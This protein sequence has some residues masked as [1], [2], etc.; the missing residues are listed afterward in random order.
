MAE[1]RVAEEYGVDAAAMLLAN[2]DATVAL[3]SGVESGAEAGSGSGGS[4][5]YN[6]QP[7]EFNNCVAHGDMV[8]VCED[9]CDINSCPDS[10]DYPDKI[11]YDCCCD[12]TNWHN[13][14]GNEDKPGWSH[15]CWSQYD[16][17][18]S[19]R[20]CTDSF[21][22]NP[23]SY[24]TMQPLWVGGSLPCTGF[25]PCNTDSNF[26]AAALET[27][28]GSGSGS[29][30]S[31]PERPNLDD[32]LKNPFVSG[33]GVSPSSF[34]ANFGRANAYQ[35]M[36]RSQMRG[37]SS[38]WKRN[39]FT[40]A[41]YS[42]S[43][44]K[45][46]NHRNAFN[47]V[48][49]AN[50][51]RGASSLQVPTGNPLFEAHPVMNPESEHTVESYWKLAEDKHAEDLVQAYEEALI[52]SILAKQSEST[53]DLEVDVKLANIRVG[54]PGYQGTVVNRRG[55]RTAPKGGITFNG[56]KYKGGQRLPNYKAPAAS[57]KAKSKPKTFAECLVRTTWNQHATPYK[58][59][60]RGPCLGF[61]I[62]LQGALDGDVAWTSI[63]A[64]IT[65][66]LLCLAAAGRPEKKTNVNFKKIGKLANSLW[67][68]SNAIMMVQTI[69]SD[70]PCNET[71]PMAHEIAAHNKAAFGQYQQYQLTAGQN[72]HHPFA[73][74]APG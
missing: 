66:C 2:L 45:R 69:F 44:V 7:G 18:I 5:N 52:H 33:R 25:S 70:D 23:V 41:R 67:C 74:H 59:G 16:S 21:C 71:H 48:P 56:K 4:Y 38:Y 37:I 17:T 24:P 42:S 47:T 43:T 35:K 22:Y 58:R 34:M 13:I 14:E 54:Q 57:V 73:Y 40:L 55:W 31:N 60:T 62:K 61:A 8:L 1:R 51:R 26:G 50:L 15:T 72:Q 39:G 64:W 30:A 53:D 3:E 49:A 63:C 20:R 46:I 10:P 27:G 68:F 19:S 29:N 36:H 11:A 12:Y 28:A 9:D 65:H 32:S 6:V